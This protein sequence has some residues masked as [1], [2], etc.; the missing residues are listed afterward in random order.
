MPGSPIRRARREGLLPPAPRGHE[1]SN[2]SAA[3]EWAESRERAR[4][5]S[6]ELVEVLPADAVIYASAKAILLDIAEHGGDDKNR[7]AAARA[8]IDAVKP[9]VPKD[10]DDSLG[11]LTQDALMSEVAAA[12]TDVGRVAQ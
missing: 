12:Q 1:Q 11:K 2:A 6:L 8:L 3:V 5:R 4:A 7:V 9:A 10:A